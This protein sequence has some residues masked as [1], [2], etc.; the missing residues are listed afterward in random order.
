MTRKTPLFFLHGWAMAPAV[1]QPLIAALGA[2]NFEIHTPALPGHDENA[3]SINPT[4]AAWADALAPAIPPTATVIGWS[5]GALLALEL[6]RTRF[7]HVERLILLG[8]T[9][10]FVSTS[11]WP[12][13]L[14]AAVVA[15]FTDGYA[16][17]PTQTLRRFLTLQ[18]LGDAYRRQLLPQLEAAAVP[19]TTSP[20]PALADGLKILTASDLR[21][22]LAKIRQP[23]HIIHGNDDALMPIEAARQL[24]AALPR[25]RL[26]VFEHCGHAPLLSRADECAAVIGEVEE[27]LTGGCPAAYPAF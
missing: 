19:H 10:R 2:E 25:A 16:S 26:T 23:V 8:V 12:H 15:S 22:Q 24:A 20:L 1:W 9:P 14:D 27:I 5:L 18:T 7:E 21:P 11:N 13:G 17:Q 4:L 6:A 3:I